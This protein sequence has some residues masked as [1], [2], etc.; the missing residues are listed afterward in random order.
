MLMTEGNNLLTYKA[1]IASTQKADVFLSLTKFII[2]PLDLINLGPNGSF[3]S[4]L[5]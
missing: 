4:K 5:R 2:V 3:T 1:L